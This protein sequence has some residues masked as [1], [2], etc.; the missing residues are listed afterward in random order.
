[1]H[2]YQLVLT[3]MRSGKSDRQIAK[4]GLMGRCTCHELRAIA[5]AQGWLIGALPEARELR[6]LLLRLTPASVPSG[7]ENYRDQ[8]LAL[9]ADGIAG[10]TIFGALKRE[11]A[12]VCGCTE[13]V[14]LV[15]CQSKKWIRCSIRPHQ[16]SQD[17]LVSLS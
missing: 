12:G 13:S 6:G 14:G 9:V 16:C 7:V 15:W 8:A 4:L 2:H 17:C 3:Q 10:T 1:M 5:A 11:G